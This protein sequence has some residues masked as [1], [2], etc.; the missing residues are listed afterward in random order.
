[1]PRRFLA[2]L[3]VIGAGLGP[4][5]GPARGEPPA[6]LETAAL[7][8]TTA[9]G[10]HRFTVEMA[11]TPEQRAQG[12]MFRRRL[13]PDHG[14]LLVY[15]AEKD[16]AIWMKNTYL[17]LDILFVGGDG[18]IRHIVERAAALSTRVMRSGVPVRAVLEL[19]AGTAA[20][21][22]IRIGDRVRHSAFPAGP[23]MSS[24]K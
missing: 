22:G 5:W 6:P 18:R 19:P 13:A 16:V 23:G 9:S 8:V 20:R 10:T 15:E 11:V 21:L 24:P 12:L 17:S 4:W 14:M 2:A 7:A 1:M 3:L